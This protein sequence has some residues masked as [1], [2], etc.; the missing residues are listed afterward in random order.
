[1]VRHA[2]SSKTRLMAHTTLHNQYQHTPNGKAIWMVFWFRCKRH[3]SCC[4]FLHVF[5]CGIARI[6]PHTPH[7]WAMISFGIPLTCLTFDSY[8]KFVCI[9]DGNVDLFPFMIISVFQIMNETG[10][11][12]HLNKCHWGEN[13]LASDKKTMKSFIAKLSLWEKY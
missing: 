11:I 4:S 2:H 10:Q 6:H 12:I 3:V 7:V 5:V 13:R 1:M 8:I 9:I